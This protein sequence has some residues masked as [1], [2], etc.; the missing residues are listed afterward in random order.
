MKSRADNAAHTR[1]RATRWKTGIRVMQRLVKAGVDMDDEAAVIRWYGSLNAA[2]QLRI[3]PGFVREIQDARGKIEAAGKSREPDPDL[4]EFDNSYRAP[5]PGPDNLAE[6]KRE[7][8]FYL[9]KLRKARGRRDSAGE[10]EAAKQHRAYSEVVH[11]AELH[12]QRLGR[13]LGDSYSAA[14][15]DR[16]GLA[17]AYWLLHSADALINQLAANLVAAAVTAPL[18][19]ERIRR[20]IDPLILR[21]RMLVPLVRATQ[22]NAGAQLP[23]RFVEAVKAGVESYVEDGAAEFARLYAAAVVDKQYSERRGIDTDLICRQLTIFV[24]K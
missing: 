8:D 13:D 18:D 23:K 3:T 2:A 7:R 19:R 16:L 11:E 22:V 24:R 10:S 15:V 1:E 12:A 9:F 6:I 5:G 20:V 14:D 4:A 21:E 17:I